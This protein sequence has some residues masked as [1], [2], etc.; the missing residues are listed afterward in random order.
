VEAEWYFYPLGIIHSDGSVEWDKISDEGCNITAETEL[1]CGTYKKRYTFSFVIMPK[2]YSQEEKILQAI[3][4]YISKEQEKEGTEILHLP[5]EI[6]GVRLN[7]K[8]REE[9][10]TFKILVLEVMAGFA[11]WYADHQKKRQEE[12]KLR[13]VMELEY[14]EITSQLMLLVGAGVNIRQAWNRISARYLDKRQKNI[15]KESPAYEAILAME[16][17][18]HKFYIFL[19]EETDRVSVVYKRHDGD[20]GLLETVY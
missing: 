12:Q 13:E 3:Q 19:N 15:V 17:L 16:Q 2:A 10:L 11:L 1:S 14:P 7:W 20:Y 9:N 18:S 5:T 6:D 8:K 4:S